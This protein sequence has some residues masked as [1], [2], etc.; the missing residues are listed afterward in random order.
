MLS[1][2]VADALVYDHPVRINNYGERVMTG[3]LVAGPDE[4][5]RTVRHPAATT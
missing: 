4:W 5:R 1:G 2:I 3:R